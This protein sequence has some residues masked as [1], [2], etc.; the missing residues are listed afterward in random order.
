MP[1]RLG[2]APGGSSRKGSWRTFRDV[3]ESWEHKQTQLQ[4][5]TLRPLPPAVST[6]QCM[7]P[8]LPQATATNMSNIKYGDVSSESEP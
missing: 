6:V 5:Q 4:S 2:A 1:V 7:H 3:A 8:R